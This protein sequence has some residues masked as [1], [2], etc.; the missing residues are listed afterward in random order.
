MENEL[1]TIQEASQLVNDSLGMN[2]NPSN[3]S[4]YENIRIKLC[5]V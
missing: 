4:Y 1:L 2:I 5:M 3:I